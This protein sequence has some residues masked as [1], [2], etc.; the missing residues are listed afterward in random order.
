MI[1]R[2]GGGKKKEKRECCNR[3]S[4]FEKTQFFHRRLAANVNG[5]EVKNDMAAGS[6]PAKTQHRAETREKKNLVE[7][8]AQRRARGTRKNFIV[9]HLAAIVDCD[10]D[11]EAL[12]KRE[13]DLVLLGSPSLRIIRNGNQL[14]RTKDIERNI[15]GNSLQGGTRC[16]QLQHEDED[17]NGGKDPTSGGNRQ[18]AKNVVEKNFGAVAHLAQTAGPIL[19]LLR[20]RCSHFN[21]N[22]QIDWRY[23]FGMRESSTESLRKVSNSARQT[24]QPFRCSPI[25]IR[26]A[27]DVVPVRASSR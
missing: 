4:G 24:V 20:L 23:I 5:A 7:L 15:V 19:R 26:S 11:L 10:I 12:R 27:A 8:M 13:L 6:R 17:H 14:R 21:A 2:T 25:C 22:S 1:L 9:Q 16:H 3:A 18:R